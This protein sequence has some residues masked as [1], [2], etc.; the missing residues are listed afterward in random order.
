MFYL[1][2]FPLDMLNENLT[3]YYEELKTWTKSTEQHNEPCTPLTQLPY[4]SNPAI[5]ASFR[6]L[7]NYLL[8]PGKIYIL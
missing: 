3:F 2:L 6:L 7:P 8:P 1:T 4:P 5:L